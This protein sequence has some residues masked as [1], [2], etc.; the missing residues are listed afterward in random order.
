MTQ[1]VEV[2]PLPAE[3]VVVNLPPGTVIRVVRDGQEPRDFLPDEEIDGVPPMRV[4]AEIPAPE[5]NGFAF[6]GHMGLA[7]LRN[8]RHKRDRKTWHKAAGAVARGGVAYVRHE[9]VDWFGTTVWKAVSVR[10]DG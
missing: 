10:K 5:L 1:I 4:I 2:R 3:T 7:G 6:V 9:Q 8:G